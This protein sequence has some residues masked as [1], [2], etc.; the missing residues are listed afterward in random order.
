M[1]VQLFYV[2]AMAYSR[3]FFAVSLGGN[4][5]AS[6][7]VSRK[8]YINVLTA[9]RIHNIYYVFCCGL[10]FSLRLIHYKESDQHHTVQCAL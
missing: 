3:C 9:Q 5:E 8:D 10:H 6:P 4:L 2:S 1:T 7:P